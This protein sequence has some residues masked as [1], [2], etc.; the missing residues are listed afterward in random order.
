M[1][2]VG[3]QW[4]AQRPVCLTNTLRGKGRVL[5]LDY[6]DETMA[7]RGGNS[8]SPFLRGPYNHPTFGDD[9]AVMYDYAFALLSRCI[10]WAAG[11]E[12]KVTATVTFDAPPTDLEAP[13]DPEIKKQGWEYKTPAAVVARKDLANL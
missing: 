6:L 8:L 12:P 10:L 5:A 9:F 11:R 2:A 7:N 1:A 3:P 13:V 4:Y